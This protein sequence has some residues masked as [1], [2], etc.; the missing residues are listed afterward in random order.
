MSDL[1]PEQV[2]ARAFAAEKYRDW[3]A[4]ML[5]D[6]LRGILYDTGWWCGMCAPERDE[7]CCEI[8]AHLRVTLASDAAPDAAETREKGAV[9]GGEG[10]SGARTPLTGEP[11]PEVREVWDRDG[12][13]HWRRRG[14]R[15]V[16]AGWGLTYER[17]ADREPGV[18]GPLYATP[19]EAD[20]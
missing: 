13:R 4:D 20:L 8:P 12:T 16:L 2:E 17:L 11:G 15:W 19:P 9:A 18:D 14:E 3:L 10:E 6:H 7:G 1:T 5:R